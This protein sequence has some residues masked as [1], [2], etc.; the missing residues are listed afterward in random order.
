MLK[1]FKDITQVP[2]MTLV[3]GEFNNKG[4]RMNYYLDGSYEIIGDF[5]DAEKEAIVK[6][7]LNCEY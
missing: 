5:A 2:E 6:K 1:I 7:W 4:F 3:E